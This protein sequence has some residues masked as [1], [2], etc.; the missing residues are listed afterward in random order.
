MTNDDFKKIQANTLPPPHTP[1]STQINLL[2]TDVSRLLNE[3]LRLKNDLRVANQEQVGLLAEM[4]QSVDQAHEAG[5]NAL[6][7]GAL[8]VCCP[9]CVEAIIQLT[10]ERTFQ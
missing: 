1:L 3:V 2:K 7:Q 9:T 6:R 4:Q 10:A 5:A 8:E